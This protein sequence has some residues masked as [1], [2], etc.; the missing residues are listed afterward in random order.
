VEDE[1]YVDRVEVNLGDVWDVGKIKLRT[2]DLIRGLCSTPSLKWI[3]EVVKD[4]FRWSS[5]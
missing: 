1:I 4:S 3:S 2:S 5:G